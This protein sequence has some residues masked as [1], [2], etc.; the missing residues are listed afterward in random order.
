MDVN[1]VQVDLHSVLCCN[2]YE[3][4]QSAF[5]A[6]GH[7]LQSYVLK[8]QSVFVRTSTTSIKTP[9]GVTS[10]CCA[11]HS[12]KLAGDD[13][14]G[15]D[16]DNMDVCWLN[17]DGWERDVPWDTWHGDLQRNLSVSDEVDKRNGEGS[18]S[19]RIALDVAQLWRGKTGETSEEDE[20]RQ[21][22]GW[23]LFYWEGGSS[24]NQ[25]GRL[26]HIHETMTPLNI[27][28]TFSGR[29]IQYWLL[30]ITK[31]ICLFSLHMHQILVG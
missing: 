9:R 28:D 19:H 4:K 20:G 15:G 14:D 18:S 25:M 30:K 24:L 6:S 8:C 22:L 27:G 12:K 5:I 23:V 10:R 13:D 2:K 21:T 1:T 7:R 31:L 11:R 17:G 16:V 26:K 29:K 3:D